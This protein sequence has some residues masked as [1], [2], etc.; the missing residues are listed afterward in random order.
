[1][2]KALELAKGKEK[3]EL[4]HW[5]GL[6]QFDKEEKVAAVKGIYEKLGIRSLT[7][8]KMASYFEEGFQQVERLQIKDQNFSKALVAVTQELMQR[9]K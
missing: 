4:Q 9:E 3:E 2:I 8:K 5:L 6:S 1:M 7:E